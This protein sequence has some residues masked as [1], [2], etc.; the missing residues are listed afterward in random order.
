MSEPIV[1]V[2]D[3]DEAVRTSLAFLLEMSDLACRTYGSALEFLE[4]ADQF[5][6]GVVVTDVRMPEMNGLELVRRLNEREI[7]LPVIV[8]TGHGDVPLAVEAMR[9]GVVD[10]IEKP[11]EQETILAAIQS[12]L[13]GQAQDDESRAEKKHY[14]ELLAGLSGRERD[15]LRGVVAGKLNKVIAHELG[16]SPRTVEVYRANVMS[17]TGA[18][19]VSELVRI[20]LMAGF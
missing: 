17:K 9:A 19:G 3:D 2:I 15:V 13:H 10:F 18:S 8:I 7:K 4:V 11:F 1:H 20:A 5:E 6:D 12:A 16:I 14:E